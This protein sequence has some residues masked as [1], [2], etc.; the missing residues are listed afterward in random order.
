MCCPFCKPVN[1]KVCYCVDYPRSTV[2]ESSLDAEYM[3]L[4]QAD[5]LTLLDTQTITGKLLLRKC[6]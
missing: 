3:K 2:V 5:H 1:R 6:P 4:K